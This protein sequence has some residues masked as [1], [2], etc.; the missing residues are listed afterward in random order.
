MTRNGHTT[1]STH[2]Y[3][4]VKNITLPNGDTI[5]HEIDGNSSDGRPVVTKETRAG[6]ETTFE[7]DDLFRIR[8][9]YQRGTSRSR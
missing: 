1:A 3:G 4:L 2:S 5:A 9:V 7:Y 8:Y 6:R